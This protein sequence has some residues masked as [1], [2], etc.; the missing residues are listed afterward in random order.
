MDLLEIQTKK[1][2]I[3]VDQ[4]SYISHA[5]FRGSWLILY[6]Y[7]L[8]HGGLSTRQRT[9]VLDSFA[10]DP[11]MKVLLMSVDAGGV[12]LN[13]TAANHVI[14]VNPWWN[15]PKEVSG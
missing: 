1:L 9:T 10:S 12:G 3:G 2:E 6:R 11:R 13:I 15:C 8:D 4:C 7:V 5:N 14:L